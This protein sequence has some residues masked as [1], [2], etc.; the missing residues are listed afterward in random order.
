VHPPRRILR[1]TYVPPAVTSPGR[2]P[3]SS[4]SCLPSRA[5]RR[6]SIEL[7][8]KE[9]RRKR[10]AM[11][12]EARLFGDAEAMQKALSFGLTACEDRAGIWLPRLPPKISGRASHTR[13]SLATDRL[14]TRVSRGHPAL[15][16]SETVWRVLAC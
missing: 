12:E 11:L 8:C 9:Q 14:A 2:V 7:K 1:P 16:R 15:V 10:E 6:S 4:C 13:H 5:A 3:S